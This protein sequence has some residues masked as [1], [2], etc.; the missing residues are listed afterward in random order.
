[1]PDNL[2]STR[3]SRSKDILFEA[4]KGNPGE[5]VWSV[6][7]VFF[8]GHPQNGPEQPFPAMAFN[9]DATANRLFALSARSMALF[10]SSVQIPNHS[11]GPDGRPSARQNPAG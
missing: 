8:T 4:A 11:L 9:A 1:V 10:A 3:R 6:E 2:C 7:K 5:R